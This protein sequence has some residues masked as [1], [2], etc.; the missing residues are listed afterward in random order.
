MPPLGHQGKLI[1]ERVSDMFNDHNQVLHERLNKH[2]EWHRKMYETLA[3]ATSSLA[4]RQDM[5]WESIATLEG[6]MRQL[7]AHLAIQERHQDTVTPPEIREM[8]PWDELPV[9]LPLQ[10]NGAHD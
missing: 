9:I 2:D 7:L 5:L 3:I 8:T 6:L 1:L 4:H 10:G